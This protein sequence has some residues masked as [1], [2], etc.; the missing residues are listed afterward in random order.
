MNRGKHTRPNLSRNGTRTSKQQQQ[1][2]RH[3]FVVVVVSLH[4]F[5]IFV[6]RMDTNFVCVGTGAIRPPHVTFVAKYSRLASLGKLCPSPFNAN[7]DKLTPDINCTVVGWQMQ[8]K[9]FNRMINAI[10]SRARIRHTG[11]YR[12]NTEKK[13]AFHFVRCVPFCGVVYTCGWIELNVCMHNGH[14]YHG[15]VKCFHAKMQRRIALLLA[16]V[17]L[18]VQI[19]GSRWARTARAS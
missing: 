17:I 19:D 11:C 12:R 8:W 15:D 16:L 7:G 6:T 18:L 4:S 3:I 5:S 9:K 2:H 13:T 14:G 1:Q 10:V